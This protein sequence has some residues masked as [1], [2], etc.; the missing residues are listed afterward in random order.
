MLSLISNVTEMVIYFV[1]FFF[2]FE[3]RK[4]T[5]KTEINSYSLKRIIKKLI[6]F[7]QFL[8]VIFFFFPLSQNSNSNP[9]NKSINS[10]RKRFKS[11][12]TRS[13]SY[14]TRT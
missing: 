3:I 2:F 1:F 14:S 13:F 9:L 5:N 10:P 11:I 12:K 8:K 6:N 7:E 4:I